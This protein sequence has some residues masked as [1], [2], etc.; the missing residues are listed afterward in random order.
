MSNPNGCNCDFC[1]NYDLYRWATIMECK[2]GCHCDDT[3]VGHDRLCC[4]FPNGKRINNP[5]KELKAAVVYNTILNKI[6]GE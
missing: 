6:K 3:I 5:Y 2:C 4:E 1:A